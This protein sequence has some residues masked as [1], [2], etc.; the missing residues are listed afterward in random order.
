M[1]FARYQV[2]EAISI[3]VGITNYSGGLNGDKMHHK[4]REKRAWSLSATFFVKFPIW[5][6]IA[7]CKI[8]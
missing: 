6:R 8:L 5:L 3:N 1:N 7:V 4:L 2:L